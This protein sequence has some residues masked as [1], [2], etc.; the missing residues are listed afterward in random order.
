MSRKK[1]HQLLGVLGT[2]MR[3]G[4]RVAVGFAS[5]LVLTAFVGG[6]GWKGLDDYSFSVDRTQR[7]RLVAD[8]VT[9]A[10]NEA[11]RYLVSQDR[12]AVESAGGHLDRAQ[13]TLREFTADDGVASDRIA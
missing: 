12:G 7:M 5:V 2:D 6:I 8:G 1:P 4:S 13:A 11:A 10:A 3:V 9:A